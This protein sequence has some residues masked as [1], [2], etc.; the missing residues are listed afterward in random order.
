MTDLE[1]KQALIDRNEEV[2]EQ[3]LF[4][5]CRR[6]FMSVIRKVFSYDVDY[7]EFVNEFYVYLMEEDAR[8]LQQFQGRSSIYQ[9]LKTTAIRYF[10]AKRNSL[11]DMAPAAPLTDSGDAEEPVDT[12]EETAARMDVEHLF[13]QMDN[14]RQV[15][16]IKKLVLEDIEPQKI[17]DELQV[18][19][20][21]LYN[22]KRRA[23]AAITELAINE[24]EHYEKR[25]GRKLH[26][27]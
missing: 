6:L 22:I 27:I 19:V 24:A 25:N 3:F 2:T 4:K 26:I 21:N 9:W 11:I 18:T 1:I 8:R 20:D 14:K 17:A 5:D 13:S 7:E 23:I 10:I 16:V 12:E 15:Y